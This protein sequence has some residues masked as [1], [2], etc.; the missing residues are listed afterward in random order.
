VAEIGT[1]KEPQELL[2]SILAIEKEMGR[3]RKHDKGPRIIDIDILLLGD[4]LVDT[5]ELTIPHPA[6]HKR[7]FVLAPLEEI[8]PE[9][10]H[11]ILKKTIQELGEDLPEGQAVRK[12]SMPPSES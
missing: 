10:R 11:P 3:E 9:M 8:A 2:A 4:R 6:M 12:I 5:G 7:R 1:Q